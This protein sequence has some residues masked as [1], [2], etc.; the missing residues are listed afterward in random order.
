MYKRK[1]WRYK[2]VSFLLSLVSFNKL[3]IKRER[4]G[5]LHL[6][7]SDVSTDAVH[8]PHLTGALLFYIFAY[9]SNGICFWLCSQ[10]GGRHHTAFV[11]VS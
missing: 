9:V 11:P 6:R 3:H 1:E 7:K 8:T 4:V 2:I 10:G 5:N